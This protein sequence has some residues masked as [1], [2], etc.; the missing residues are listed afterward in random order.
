MNPTR[1]NLADIWYIKFDIEPNMAYV[2][3]MPT[4]EFA[5][6]KVYRLTISELRNLVI[7]ETIY[8]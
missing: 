2:R 7:D 3:M 1:I 5:S 4:S 8:I 6:G